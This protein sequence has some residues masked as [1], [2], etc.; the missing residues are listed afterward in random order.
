MHMTLRGGLMIDTRAL[1]QEVQDQL[2]AAV[3]RGQKQ[4][5]KSQDQVRKGQDQV[6]RSREA[7]ADAIRTGNERAKAVRSNIP[8]LPVRSPALNTLADPA[9]LRA[10]SQELADQFLASQRHLADRALSGQ[11]HLAD[12]AVARQRNFADQAVE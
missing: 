6:R 4:L 7:V 3:H 5:R 12:R 10:R 9:K 8:A 1:A 11:R 2:V